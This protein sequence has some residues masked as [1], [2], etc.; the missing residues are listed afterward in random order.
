MLKNIL[1]GDNIKH[2]ISVSDIINGIRQIINIDDVNIVASYYTDSTPV[3]Y[4]ASKVNGVYTNCSLDS[5]NNKLKVVLEGYSMENGILYCNLQIS[6]PDPDFPDG[7][8]N[9]TRLIKT[10][11]CLTDAN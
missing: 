8:A 6:V 2:I 5:V 1:N 10:N 4:V 7:Y 3:P 11:I 9:Y